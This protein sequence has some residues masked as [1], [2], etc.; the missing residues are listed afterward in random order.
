MDKNIEG[1]PFPEKSPS[2]ISEIQ[3]RLGAIRANL[4]AEKEKWE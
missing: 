3:N 2:P 4:L 1:K